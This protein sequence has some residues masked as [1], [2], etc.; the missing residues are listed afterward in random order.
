M[1]SDH[2]TT[3][4]ERGQVLVFFALL[5]PVFITLAAVVVAGGNWYTHAKHLQT[6]ADASA[7]AGGSAWSFPCT[8]GSDAP[9]VTAARDY[10]GSH[11]GAGGTAYPGGYNQQ[12]GGVP[13]SN[14]QVRLNADNWFDDEDG[15]DPLDF[16][17][18]SGGVCTAKTLDVKATEVNSFP[19]AS[20]IPLFPDLKRKARV[21]IQEGA[22]SAGPGLLPL[23]VRV[24][25]PLNAAAV[26]VNETPGPDFGRILSA[27]YFNDVCEPP[28]NANCVAGMPPGLDH[29]TTDNGSG[30]NR[31]TI[32]AMPAQVGVVVALS[33]RPKCPGTACF[34]IDYTQP[35]LDTIDEF[36]NQG[37]TAITQCYYTTGTSTQT[38]RS[39][40]QFIRS[41]SANAD[42][43]PDLLSTWIEPPISGSFCYQGYFSSPVSNPCIVTLRANVDPGFGGVGNTE[44]RY[45]HVSGNT[46]ALSDDPP[47][48]CDNNF[49]PGCDMPAGI[50]T[51]QLNEAHARHAVAIQVLRYNIS[52]WAALGLPPNCGSNQ[53]NNACSW[54]FTGAGRSQTSPNAAT[55]FANP[56][57]RA[58]M[59][60]ILRSGPVKYLHLKN[61]DC[62]NGNVLFG[63][64]VTGEAASVQSGQRC[65]RLEMG[66]QGALAREQDEYPIQINIGTTSQS[67]VVDCDPD[68]SNLKTEIEEG[69]GAPD[70]FPSYTAHDFARV[71]NG[72]GPQNTPYCPDIN[73]VNQFFDVNPPK[74]APYEN[75]PAFTCVLTQPCNNCNQ[76]TQG[77]HQRIFGVQNNPTC[78]ADN[79]LFVKGRNYWHDANNSFAADP[80]G[81][82]P[83]LVQQDFFT[84]TRSS[85]TEPGGGSHPNRLRLDDPRFVLLFISP[86]SSFTGQG[87]ANY[88]I[89]AIGGF[90]ITGYGSVG[91]PGN[92][93]LV[94]EDPCDTGN[95]Q[96]V[97][98][99]NTPPPDVNISEG[100]AAVAWGHFVIA[101]NLSAPG[102]GN[103][104]PCQD[105]A[106]T[107]CVSVLVE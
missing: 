52:N 57:Q 1:A 66:L 53:A 2:R 90:Y 84:F 87:N 6:K 59:G 48:G 97:G 74:A 36:C 7:L 27:V 39:G 8:A 43:Q 80:D 34:N 18:P 106:T 17:T 83:L 96:G 102:G 25:K 13:G 12:V 69:C 107:S 98:S 67:A 46:G 60:D 62:G 94:V 77:F 20:I 55:V 49:G 103:G 85:R 41:W 30:G 73:S 5:F 54:Y 19:L 44:I 92:P 70:G 9:I 63:A 91:S 86:Y 24:P 29:W 76:I 71:D 3:S 61:V 21:E 50:A 28:A 75:W 72:S 104:N 26:Y 105:G 4:R 99:G 101:M 38:F 79:A 31:A 95:G 51:L 45:K 58:F 89:T 47:G 81:A 68:K 33:H 15:V 78:P 40:L 88:P 37:T 14:I 23:A 93:Q 42:P 65:F 64:I 32:A 10:V 82:G 22:E 35:S 16:T 11:I 56:V 100:P